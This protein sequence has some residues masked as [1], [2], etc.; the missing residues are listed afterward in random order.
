MRERIQA[1]RPIPMAEA[2]RDLTWHGRSAH[3]TKTD[4]D[5]L[6]VVQEF[7]A[8]EMALASDTKLSEANETI[9]LALTG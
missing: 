2:V 3:L 1:A 4:A 9:E 6:K 8:A 5:L 7:L